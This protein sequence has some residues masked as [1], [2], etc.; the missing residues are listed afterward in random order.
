M[1]PVSA[2]SPG[3]RRWFNIEPVADKG[4]LQALLDRATPR[5]LRGA[6][7]QRR[8]PH[9]RP[10][11][12]RLPKRLHG[13]ADDEAKNCRRRCPAP[14]V[15]LGLLRNDAIA[16]PT[17]TAPSRQGR[18]PATPDMWRTLL[19]GSYEPTGWDDIEDLRR[20]WQRSHRPQRLCQRR[21]RRHRGRHRH[22]CGSGQQP[23]RPATG[24]HGLTAGRPARKSSSAWTVGW[25][26]SSTAASGADPTSSRRSHW[27]RRLRD[28]PALSLRTGRGRPG[29]RLARRA[30]VDRGDDP[31]PD[32]PG[33][34]ATSRNSATVGRALIRHRNQH[35]WDN[36]S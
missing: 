26:S 21:G 27:G 35:R 24:P 33:H 2:S 18:W 16:F 19:A 31:N 12:A 23:R 22:R 17:W 28:R 5:G 11:R 13:P 4:A 10:S 20:R 15:G 3:L 29:R 14:P 25:R 6:A 8:L 32:A 36:Q 7:G 30:L 1:E 34:F 9:H